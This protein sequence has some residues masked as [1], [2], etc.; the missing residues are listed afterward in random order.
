[1]L[2][3]TRLCSFEGDLLPD[4][5][6][7]R[8]LIGRLLYLTVSRPDITFTIH[9]L[10][11]F[12][13]QPRQPH[14]DAAHHLLRYLKTAPGQGLFFSANSSLQLRA[15]SDADWGSCLDSR[16]STTGFCIFLG[17]SMISWK[18]KKQSIVSRSSAEAEYR[19]LASTASELAAIHIASNPVFHERTKHIELDCHFIR[20]KLVAGIV[21]LLPIRSRHQLA[22]VFT[23]ALPASLLFPLLAKMAVH[24][25]H[26]PS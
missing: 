14:L 5:S 2:P 6:V 17:D 15:F 9:K 21:K 22:D 19:A 10:S 24:D 16:Q 20:E 7:Y 11:Q 18:A 1:M 25:I 23:K 13:S 3:N 12:I 26:S 4:P 8:R